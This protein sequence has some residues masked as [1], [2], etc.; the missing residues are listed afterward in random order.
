MADIDQIQSI[1]TDSN[2][3]FRENTRAESSHFIREMQNGLDVDRRRRREDHAIFKRNVC[4][5]QE[6]DH[7]EWMLYQDEQRCTRN[8][9]HESNQSILHQLLAIGKRLVNQNNLDN[10]SNSN[11][12]NIRDE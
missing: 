11:N 9:R 2:A 1:L 6:D 8:E 3:Q 4:Q 10:S 7:L 12:N 5:C